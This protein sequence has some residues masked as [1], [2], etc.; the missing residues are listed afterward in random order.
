MARHEMF[1]LVCRFFLDI[2]FF[3]FWQ[4]TSMWTFGMYFGAVL[5]RAMILTSGE[6]GLWSSR[7]ALWF[8]LRSMPRSYVSSSP[9]RPSLRRTVRVI[10][11][12]QNLK[13]DSMPDKWKNQDTRWEESGRKEQR[14]ISKEQAKRERDETTTQAV[15]KVSQGKTCSAQARRQAREYLR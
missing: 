9:S 6:N 14:W 7:V 3:I 15:E 10:P 2:G 11:R 12:R 5:K 1:S 8:W 13:V 4:L